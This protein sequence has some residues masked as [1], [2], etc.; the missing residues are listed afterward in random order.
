MEVVRRATAGAPVGGVI[1]VRRAEP[2]DGAG[3]QETLLELLTKS[4]ILN[5]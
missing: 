4:G 1:L 2:K 5:R 3:F